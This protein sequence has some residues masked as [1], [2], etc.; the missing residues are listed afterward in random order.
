MIKNCTYYICAKRLDTCIVGFVDFEKPLH[1]KNLGRF[2]ICV[3]C[4]DQID[5]KCE[6]AENINRDYDYILN[7]LSAKVLWVVSWQPLSC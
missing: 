2:V 3:N 4:G 1:E 5:K 7:H 6:E